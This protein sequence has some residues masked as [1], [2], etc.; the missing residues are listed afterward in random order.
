MI[1]ESPAWKNLMAHQQ[2]MAKTNLQELFEDDKNRKKNYRLE[3]AGLELDFSR[4][5]LT[6]ETLSLLLT[7]ANDSELSS[8]INALFSGETV[9]RTENRPALHTVLRNF[10]QQIND[11]LQETR[12][13]VSAVLNQMQ[14]FCDA[15]LSGKWCSYTG[16]QFT[17][18]VHIGIGGSVLG[19]KLVIEALAPYKIA[20]LHCHFVANL[21][22]AAIFEILSSLNAETTLFIIASKSFT[23][24]ETVCNAEIAKAWLTEKLDEKAF[25]KHFVAITA[26]PD[27]AQAWNLPEQTIFPFWDWVGGRYSLWSAIGLSIALTIGMESFQQLLEGAAAM[28]AHFCNT[29]FEKNMP[30]LFALIGIWYRNFFNTTSHAIIPYSH[31]LRSLPEYLQQLE[32]E[33]NGKSVSLRDKKVLYATAPLIWGGAGTTSQ[34]AF[35]QWLHQGT[36][37]T[38]ADFIVAKHGY[39]DEAQHKR[40]YANCLAQMEVLMHGQHDVAPYQQLPGNRPSL[41]ISM[42]KLTPYRLGSLLALYEHKVFVQG[43]I[44]QINSFDQ[45][46]VEAGKKM[47]NA[48]WRGMDGS[49]TK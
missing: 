8:Q 32:M 34:H 43:V 16:K 24:E 23:T 42:D 29:S 9:N 33:S 26:Y 14:N 30:V 36:D 10:N 38:P 21:D 41:L 4:T 17:D 13:Q 3:A 49:L 25:A 19:P 5:H 15:V 44:W 7:L 6:Q 37:L 20:N 47:A 22:P 35:H 39:Y 1:Q 48:I 45:W 28:D 18:I 11:T 46:G 40:L 27:R 31:S 2:T 12:A